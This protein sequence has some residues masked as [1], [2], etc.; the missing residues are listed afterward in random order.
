MVTLG[1]SRNASPHLHLTPITPTPALPPSKSP[2]EKMIEKSSKAAKRGKGDKQLCGP[3]MPH[4]WEEALGPVSNLNPCEKEKN[5]TLPVFLK[6]KQ[7]R[8]L[9]SSFF[10]ALHQSILPTPSTPTI[11]WAKF[12][13]HKIEL[14]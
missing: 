6:K 12:L 5:K 14:L 8:F 11:S 13:L 4:S 7:P 1:A 2:S 3:S 9:A 10:Q